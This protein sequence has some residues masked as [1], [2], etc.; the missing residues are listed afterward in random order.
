MAMC[1]GCKQA[2]LHVTTVLKTANNAA[3]AALLLR[4]AMMGVGHKVRAPGTFV[5]TVLKTANNAALA[6]S[7]LRCAMMGVGHKV[8]AP[9]TLSRLS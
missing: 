9:G 7:L 6:A 5:T 1:S 2:F 4:C 3:L 8:R